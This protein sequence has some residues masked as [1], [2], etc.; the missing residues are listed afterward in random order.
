MPRSVAL[1]S[2]MKIAIMKVD[3]LI[4]DLTFLPLLL[5][6]PFLTDWPLP[7][8]STSSYRLITKRFWT[9]ILLQRTFTSLVNAHVGRTPGIS[10]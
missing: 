4:Q 10:T 6:R 2:N 8:T 7:F 9:V 1:L 5:P 3:V